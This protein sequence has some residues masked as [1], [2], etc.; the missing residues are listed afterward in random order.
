MVVNNK[1]YSKEQFDLR[2]FNLERIKNLEI[3][4]MQLSLKKEE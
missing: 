3:K 4:M 1:L 2:I